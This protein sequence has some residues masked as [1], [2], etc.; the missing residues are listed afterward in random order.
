M[1]DNFPENWL[2][3]K[4]QGEGAEFSGY[5][6]FGV[7]RGGYLGSDMWQLNSGIVSV[8]EDEN[9]FNFKG[10]SGSVYICRKSNYGT[11]P[12]GSRVINDI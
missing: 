6:I 5:R 1:S 12:Y 9:N 2:I 10:K 7:W 3:L 4:V 11:S 8:T